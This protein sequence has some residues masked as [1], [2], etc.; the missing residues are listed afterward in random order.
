M[1]VSE[2]RLIE[3]LD[4]VLNKH[5]EIDNDRHSVHHQFVEMEMQRREERHRRWEKV[6]VQVYGWG[7]ITLLSALGWVGK[8]VYDITVG[9]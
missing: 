9:Q 6:K 1:S 3:V 2:E 5:R 8:K 4:E 7:I